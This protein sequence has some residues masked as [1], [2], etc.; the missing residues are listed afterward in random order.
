MGDI[1]ARHQHPRPSRTWPRLALI[2]LAAGALGSAFVVSAGA[3][4]QAFLPGWRPI[5]VAHHRAPSASGGSGV[6]VA[7]SPTAKTVVVGESFTI[8]VVVDP[9][10]VPVDTVHA[11]MTFDPAMLQVAFVTG[12]SSG[13]DVEVDNTF[14]NGA[15]TLTHRRE[16]SSGEPTTAPFTLCT[17]TFQAFGVT[18]GTALWFTSATDA[19][20]EGESVLGSTSGAVVVVEEP[21]T[22]TAAPSATITLTPSLTP[23]PSITLT[24]SRTPTATQTATPTAS[25]TP[26]PTATVRPTST[27]TPTHTPTPVATETP[28]AA[29]QRLYLPVVLR[30]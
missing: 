16:S 7:V 29:G 17:I 25:S 12:H 14:D 10:E 4:G 13:L 18:E 27:T 3:G 19:Y 15:G 26:Y 20:L 2:L 21:A 11:D 9:N 23:T 5:P 8:A 30:R 1:A 6:D 24:P 22:P 28:P